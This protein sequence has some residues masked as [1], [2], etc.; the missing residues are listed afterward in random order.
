M[1]RRLVFVAIAIALYVLAALAAALLANSAS[2]PVFRQ[3]F[4]ADFDTRKELLDKNWI[5]FRY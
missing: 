1:T 2:R 4:T 5:Y 3:L